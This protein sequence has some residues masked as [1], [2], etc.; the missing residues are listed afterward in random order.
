MRRKGERDGVRDK[1]GMNWGFT[2]GGWGMEW[3]ESDE[4]RAQEF[5]GR[6][7]VGGGMNYGSRDER[8]GWTIG[9]G[10]RGEDEW[11]RRGELRVQKWGEG[12]YVYLPS[13]YDI[14]PDVGL[15]RSAHSEGERWGRDEIREGWSEMNQG[16]SGMMEGWTD[17]PEMWI[18]ALLN[19]HYLLPLPI[20]TNHLYTLLWLS[21]SEIHISYTRNNEKTTLSRTSASLRTNWQNMKICMVKILIPIL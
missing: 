20:Q 18:S 5:R 7:T 13:T 12:T 14:L 11:R 19:I 16:W 4:L 1:E 6:V 8:K 3:D 9:P 17:G 21:K 2:D 10:T 15:S